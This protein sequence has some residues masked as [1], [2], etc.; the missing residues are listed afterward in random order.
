MNQR[1]KEDAKSLIAGSEDAAV[2]LFNK[3]IWFNKS[4]DRSHRYR[5]VKSCLVKRLIKYLTSRLNWLNL[6]LL[7]IISRLT[8][9]DFPEVTLT[10]FEI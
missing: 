4:F 6:V 1:T 9:L 10:D 2:N 7:N 3:S 8:R 5:L